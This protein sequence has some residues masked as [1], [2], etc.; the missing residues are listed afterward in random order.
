MGLTPEFLPMIITVT[1]AQGAVRLAREK[2]I[3]TNLSAIQNFGSI[4]VLCSDKT[5]TLTTGEMELEAHVD[6][7][8]EPSER[9]FLLAYLNSYF[10][11]GVDNPV[12]AAVL[13]RSAVNP[14]DAARRRTTA[15]ARPSAPAV[16]NAL[17]AL[18]GEP[19]RRLPL[20]G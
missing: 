16:C 10:E 12:D 20:L 5:G 19:V 14:L 18:A 2:V 9:P 13:R 11:S 4:D 17:R 15:R 1:L 7:L 3:V 8:G 6:P